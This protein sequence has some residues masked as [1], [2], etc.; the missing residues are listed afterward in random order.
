MKS[1]KKFAKF[2]SAVFI[3]ATLASGLW[4][5]WEWNG[6]QLE[7]NEYFEQ[8]ERALNTH[9]CALYFTGKSS[10]LQGREP[11]FGEAALKTAYELK[12]V[13]QKEIARSGIQLTGASF[14]VWG[15]F[16]LAYLWGSH[17]WKIDS[18]LD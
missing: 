7:A 18:D 17:R 2:L 11:S 5:L 16:H 4:S 13:E 1:F 8:C 9:P 10:T 12:K 6:A 15:G 14:A 3:I